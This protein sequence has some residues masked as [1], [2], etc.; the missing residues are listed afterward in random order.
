[1]TPPFVPPQWDEGKSAPQGTKIGGP[2]CGEPFQ[3]CSGST[4]AK[5]AAQKDPES[6]NSTQ[7]LTGLGELNANALEKHGKKLSELIIDGERCEQRGQNGNGVKN[8]SSLLHTD[9]HCDGIVT[10]SFL[11]SSETENRKNLNTFTVLKKEAGLVLDERFFGDCN[12]EEKQKKRN[13]GKSSESPIQLAV[14]DKNG[15]DN[16]ADC[17]D[18]YKTVQTE[19]LCCTANLNSSRDVSTIASGTQTT[20]MNGEIPTSARSESLGKTTRKKRQDEATAVGKPQF[21]H[22]PK[23]IFK[24]TVQVKKK[25]GII[26]LTL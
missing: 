20:G 14:S 9:V 15:F 18:N 16:G 19:Q 25:A 11:N 17:C 22:P 8:S 26:S 21:Q 24:P 5:C 2:D 1:M 3:R 7:K 10:F 12:E 4:S 23:R 6:L 13:D